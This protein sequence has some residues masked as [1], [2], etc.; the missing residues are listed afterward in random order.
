MDHNFV[1]WTSI[2]P[3]CIGCVMVPLY[4]NLWSSSRALLQSSL[5][6]SDAS[7]GAQHLLVEQIKFNAPIALP[8]QACQLRDQ[9]FDL[10][11]IYGRVR[12]A[13]TAGCSRCKPLARCNSS[14]L[15]LVWQSIGRRLRRPAHVSSGE[16]VGLT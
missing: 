14:G 3:R 7:G 6:G 5:L 16:Y 8:L 9:A 2:C 1:S 11:I 10:P 13:C 4:L 12:V 15:P